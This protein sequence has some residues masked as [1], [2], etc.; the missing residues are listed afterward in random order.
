MFAHLLLCQQLKLTHNTTKSFKAIW[1]FGSLIKLA[2]TCHQVLT[3]LLIM[4][5]VSIIMLLA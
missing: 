4:L 5:K 3:L 2:K 1:D